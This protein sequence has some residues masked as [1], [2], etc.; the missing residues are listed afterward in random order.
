MRP[1][2]TCYVDESIQ[3][4]LGVVCSA[5]VFVEQ[6]VDGAI[7]KVLVDAGFDPE[8]TEYKSSARMTG[9]SSM[10]QVREGLMSI[11]SRSTKIAVFFGPFERSRLGRQTLQALQ[12]IVVRNGFD[13]A[14]L[15]VH[16]DKEIFR[17]N[18]AA[19]RLLGCFTA[20]RGC[21][22]HGSEDSKLCRGIQLADAVA[23]S[24]GQII[25]A[26]MNGEEKKINIGGPNTGYDEGTMA[27]LSWELLMTLRYALL[28]R[29]TAS[30]ASNYDPATDPVL[31]GPD[32][33][34][35][36]EVGQHPVFLGWGVQVAPESSAE[37][38]NAVQG[39][40]ARLWL[41]CI[42]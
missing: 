17:T 37:L 10:Q 7:R 25:K 2:S 16:F 12:S 6:D 36:I 35:Q 38:S 3:A 33:D 11:A 13:P 29:P 14:G 24:F 30:D 40:L 5:F 28:T 4:D 34:D 8:T 42:H 20:L 19:E 22:V 9:N 1:Y 27:P 41:G 18:A 21:E 32:I 15:V 23:H 39:R 26:A 31:P